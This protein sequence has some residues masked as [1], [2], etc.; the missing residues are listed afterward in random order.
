[1]PAPWS[2]L[3]R[4][5]QPA[6]YPAPGFTGGDGVRPLFYDGEPWQGKPTRVFA[7]YGV[8]PEAAKGPVPAMVLVHGGGGT[9]FSDWV[10]LWLR[11]GYA[12]LAMDT[13]GGVPVWSEAPYFSMQWPRH[14]HSGPNGWGNFADVGKPLRDQW[15]WHAIGAILRGHTWLRQQPEVDPERIGLTG[16]SW[17]G[18]LTCLLAGLDPR[19]RFAAPVYGSG[20]L[21]LPSVGLC[22]PATTDPDVFRQWLAAWDPA[23]V[24]PQARLPM[25]WVNGTND[26]AFPMNAVQ[27]SYRTAPGLHTL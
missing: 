14:A 25:L 20:F 22:D 11:R 1:M 15:P 9:A 3:T 18:Y 7:W 26:F 10:R 8:P 27:R 19:L 17:G 5:P 21:D 13:C 16:I 24:L 4:F 12:A 23:H 6:A 2:E